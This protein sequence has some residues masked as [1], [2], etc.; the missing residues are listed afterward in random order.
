MAPSRLTANVEERAKVEIHKPKPWH[1]WREF[2]KEYGIIVLGVLTAI[3]LEQMVE[4]IHRQ[5]ERSELVESLKNETDQILLDTAR[6]EKSEHG[7]IAWQRQVGAI[8][9][10]ASRNR[11]P[12][13]PFPPA[14]SLNFDIPDDPIYRA[15]QSS[16]KLILLSKNE[17]EA[18]SEMDALINRVG[19]AYGERGDAL[20]ATVETQHQLRFNL[21]N[22]T[23]VVREDYTPATGFAAL[24]GSN[25]SSQEYEKLFDATVRVEL[26]I[27]KFVFW[28]RQARG[29]AT[30]LQRGERKLR[31]IEAAERQ[32]DGLP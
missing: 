14:P 6:V 4:A 23:A 30:A 12:L 25:L 16:G 1:G 19:V 7:E 31:N 3:T 2:L 24:V 32:F 17:R 15:A 20:N 13:G 21:P 22:R 10:A 9:V 18:Y 26:K 5:N 11:Q 8:L 29:A 28:S 27:S